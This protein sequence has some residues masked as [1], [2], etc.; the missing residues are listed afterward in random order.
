[1]DNTTKVL[2][3]ACFVLIGSLGFLS[4]VFLK[5]STVDHYDVTIE[6]DEGVT[7]SPQGPSWHRVMSF[8]GSGSDYRC[9]DIR[10]NKFKVVI[11]AAPIINYDVNT[12]TVDVLRDGQILASGTADWGPTES[13]KRKKRMIEVSG[14]PGY[15]CI[16]VYAY[17]IEDWEV[18]VWDYY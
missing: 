4:G 11:S 2:I 1:M 8:T 5:R 13:P 6:G 18:T 12:V 14:G 17:E 3:V 9:V 15:Y 7:G 16:S 10:G